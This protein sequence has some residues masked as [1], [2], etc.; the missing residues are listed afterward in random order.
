MSKKINLNDLTVEEYEKT[1]E[2]LRETVEKLKKIKR[3]QKKIRELEYEKN[4]ILKKMKKR[5]HR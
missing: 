5:K 2:D 4:H 1:V 3:R